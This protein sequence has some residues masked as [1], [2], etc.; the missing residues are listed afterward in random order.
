MN[1]CRIK[2]L[3]RAMVC[4]DEISG[5]DK[6]HNSIGAGLRLRE[7]RA[8]ACVEPIPKRPVLLSCERCKSILF[9]DTTW[10]HGSWPSETAAILPQK[11]TIENLKQ[12]VLRRVRDTHP[13]RTSRSVSVQRKR[14]LWRDALAAMKA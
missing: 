14:T 6:R 1:S 8:L 9:P 13:Q 2:R 5:T 3:G 4:L 12:H 10:Q 7:A 11:N